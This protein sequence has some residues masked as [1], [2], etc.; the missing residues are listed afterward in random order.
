MIYLVEFESLRGARRELVEA[1]NEY[2]AI[3]V[4]ENKKVC[5]SN[6]EIT[7]TF[8]DIWKED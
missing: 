4:V 8:Y 5:A 7:D 6:I 1:D 3:R 2:D